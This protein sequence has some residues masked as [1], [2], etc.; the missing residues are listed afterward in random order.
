MTTLVVPSL[1]CLPEYVAALQRGWSSSTT[2][3][4]SGQQLDQIA[5]DAEAFIGRLVHSQGLVVNASG[6]TVPLLAGTTRWIWDEGFCGSINIR[7][8][9]GSVELPPHVS[10]HIGYSIVPWRQRQGHAT[11]ALR[12][13]LKLAA[14][15]GL[16]YVI[17]TCDTDNVGSRKVIESAGGVFLQEM[18]DILVEGG[19]KLVFRVGY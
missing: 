7:H 15:Y 4:V 1:A 18:E 17:I 2:R 10:G 14:G 19:R 8:Q 6:E 5:V 16:P 12:L 3:D 13:M 11:A 9:P